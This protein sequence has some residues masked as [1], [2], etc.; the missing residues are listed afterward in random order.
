MA[1]SV[2]GKTALV[3]GAGSGIN[4]AFARILLEKGCSVIIADL[5]LQP[6]AETLLAEFPFPAPS[7]KPGALF[8][9]TNVASWPQLT[10]LWKTTLENFTTVDVVVLGAGLFEPKWSSFW[11]APRTDTNPDTVSVDPADSDPG[12]Y[13]VLDVNLTSPIRLSQLAIGHWSKTKQKGCLVHV[14]SIA[15]YSSAITTPLYFASK[16]GLHGFVRALSGLRDELGIRTPLWR[17]DP[18]KAVM[19]NENTVLIEPD[20]IAA[21]MW[22]LTVNEKYGNGTI[23]EVTKGQTRVIPEFGLEPP[24]GPGCVVPGYM[25]TQEALYENLRTK[26]LNV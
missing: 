8:H 2:E 17:D 7:G 25:A 20:E 16:H 5:K 13:A 6:E 26:G 15:G 23:L 14:G 18:T 24:T 19:L 10:T 9:K 3:T 12:H 4:L 21:A 22:E 1:I 11:E